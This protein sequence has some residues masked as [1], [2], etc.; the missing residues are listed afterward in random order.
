M[1]AQAMTDTVD[2]AQ[3]SFEDALKR[4][5][6]IVHKLETGEA[7]LEESIDLYAEGDRLRKHCEEKLKAATQRIEQ[8][9]LAPGG[10]PAGVQ[11]FDAG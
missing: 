4:L 5:E 11:P 2:I 8:I 3:L 9:Q 6:V 7:S 1:M 10:V